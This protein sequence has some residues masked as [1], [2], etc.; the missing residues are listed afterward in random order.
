MVSR[1]LLPLAMLPMMVL[2]RSA[3][4]ATAVATPQPAGRNC[5]DPGGSFI[6]CEALRD[7]LPLATGSRCPFCGGMSRLMGGK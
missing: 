1:R 4:F 7:M 2:P 5:G 6:A 3:G